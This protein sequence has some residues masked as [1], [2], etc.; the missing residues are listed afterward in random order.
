M[1]IIAGDKI[2][3]IKDENDSFDFYLDNEKKTMIKVDKNKWNKMCK[4]VYG[5][6]NE[7]LLNFHEQTGMFKE[8]YIEFGVN[9]INIYNSAV[10]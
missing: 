8:A 2:L 1:N 6:K 3:C 5:N 10:C 4:I 7:Y 9:N